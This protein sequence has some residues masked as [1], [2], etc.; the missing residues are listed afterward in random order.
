MVSRTGRTGQALARIGRRVR[1]RHSPRIFYASAGQ[2][3]LIRSH[4]Y[5]RKGE[6]NPDEVALTFSGQIESFVAEIEGDAMLVSDCADG[7]SLVD[8]RFRLEHW[9][10]PPRASGLAFYGAALRKTLRLLR[11]ARRFR[12]NVAI[13]DSGVVPFFMMALFR[14]AGLR[15]VVVLHNSIWPRGFRRRSG[16]HGIVMTLDGFFFRRWADAVI[17]VSPEAARQVDELAPGHQ[18]IVMETRA[19]FEPDYFDRIPQ[20]PNW[21]PGPFHMMYIGRIDRTKGALDIPEIARQVERVLPGRVRWTICGRG[22]DL[23]LLQAEV[24]KDLAH[25]VDVRGWTSLEDLIGV[26]ARTHATIVPTRSSFAEGLAM[27]VVEAVMAG[28]PVVTNPVVPAHELFADAI[29]LGRTDDPA[30]HADAVI[31]LATNRPCY[32]ALQAATRASTAPFFDRSRGLTAVLHEVMVY[33]DA[34]AR[35]RR[36]R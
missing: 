2:A 34:G 28:R 10:A 7:R 13:L 6:N 5:W 31:R 14:L 30:S 29:L 32:D 1:P 18:C 15:V 19:Q 27:T 36:D 22:P 17:A 16:K 21:S 33:L 26:Y 4:A 20:P 11:A 9:P 3:N 23:R 25:I 12:A 35:H 8:G 24:A